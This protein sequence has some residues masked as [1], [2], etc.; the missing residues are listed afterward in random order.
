MATFGSS[1]FQPHDRS[2]SRVQLAMQ[3]ITG[4]KFLLIDF[5]PE[6]SY[7]PI[8]YPVA[9]IS[10][11]RSPDALRF[12]AALRTPESAAIFAREGFA[13]LP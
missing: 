5:Y 12:L 3:G 9:V 8:I 6:A 11:S 7:P 13:V 1:S 4:V 10:G 2:S